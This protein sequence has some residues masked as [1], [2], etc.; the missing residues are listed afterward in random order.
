MTGRASPQPIHFPESDARVAVS[1]DLGLS[2]E[3]H[4]FLWSRVSQI[5]Q[6]ISSHQRVHETGEVLSDKDRKAWLKS[7]ISDF[8]RLRHQLA[9]RRSRTTE[10]L[11]ESTVLPALAELLGHH[12][13]EVL[14]N[15]RSHFWLE[16]PA[17]YRVLF[18]GRSASVLNIVN[19]Q[20][21]LQKYISAYI[22]SA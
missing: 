6:T 2:Q 8:E 13:L 18:L 16:R 19:L 15:G 12:G 22:L 11:L 20:N 4:E 14:S 17:G 5:V 9:A 1:L 10:A 3:Q 21:A 7:T